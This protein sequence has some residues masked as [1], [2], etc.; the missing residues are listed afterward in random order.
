MGGGVERVAREAKNWMRGGH[1]SLLCSNT[2]RAIEVL[3]ALSEPLHP[4]CILILNFQRAMNVV[5]VDV[6]C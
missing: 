1:D 3:V 2:I 6:Q 4:H 5:A